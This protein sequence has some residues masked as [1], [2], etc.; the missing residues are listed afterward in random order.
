MTTCWRPRILQFIGLLVLVASR[1]RALEEFEVVDIVDG[2]IDR[3]WVYTCWSD[4]HFVR[5]S[6]SYVATNS[7]RYS[8]GERSPSAECGAKPL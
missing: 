7:R 5:H 6:L 2:T 1:A 4:P 3:V 8:A